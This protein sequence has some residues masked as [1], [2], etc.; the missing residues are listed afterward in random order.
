MKVDPEQRKK[1]KK[2]VDKY[3]K[4]LAE[5]DETGNI[6]DD[7]LRVDH[8]MLLEFYQQ[9]F[10][11]A[12]PTDDERL[13]AKQYFKEQLPFKQWKQEREKDPEGAMPDIE[14]FE[15][16]YNPKYERITKRRTVR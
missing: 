8:P 1:I 9:K 16:L 5:K 15:E 14:D 4:S 12:L 10:F 13:V 7:G 11:L 6:I 2:E 3:V